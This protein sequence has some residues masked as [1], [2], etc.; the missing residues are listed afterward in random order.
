[1]VLDMTL[2]A[3]LAFLT[4]IWVWQRRPWGDVLAGIFL[5]KAIT[6]MTSFLIADYI[7]WFSGVA[8]NQGAII[9]F[10]IIYIFVYIFSW[11]YFSAFVKT[12]AQPFSQELAA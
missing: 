4:G 10:S 1:M 3:P 2:V 5:I 7:N 11:N 8:N 12:E 9:A 6:I